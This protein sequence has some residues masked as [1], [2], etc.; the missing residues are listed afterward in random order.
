MGDACGGIFEASH[1]F[2]AASNWNYLVATAAAAIFISQ[3]AFLIGG[4]FRLLKVSHRE[5]RHRRDS[6]VFCPALSQLSV[7]KWARRVGVLAGDCSLDAQTVGLLRPR[8]LVSEGLAR[9]LDSGHLSAVLAHEEAHRAAR[10]NLF[11]VMAKSVA[12]TLF[13][14][15]GPRLA[16]REM[17]SSLERAA[18][19]QAAEKT[20]GRLAVAEALARIAA[21]SVR[22]SSDRLLSAALTGNGSDIT[23]RVE[24]LLNSEEPPRG[25]HWRQLILFAAG[26]LVVLGVFASSAMAVADSDQRQAFV[27][28]TQHEQIADTNGICDLD[29]PDHP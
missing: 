20:G 18:D 4:G 26:T 15:P 19:Q 11:V 17:R 10:D 29:H 3:L 27:C 14:L 25:R 5:K 1:G 24:V 21:A 9:T 6:S 13:Y 7:K 2:L 8:I 23:S 12:L 16:F 28:F 22:P